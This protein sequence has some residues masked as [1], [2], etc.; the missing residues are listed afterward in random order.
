MTDLSKDVQE[1][2]KEALSRQTALNIYAGNSKAFIG[3]PVSGEPCCLAGHS[4]ILY[5]QPTEL[6]LT[7]RSGTPLSLIEQTLAEN[8]QMLAFEP[9]HFS[10]NA[11]LGGVVSSALSGP[12]SVYVGTV[13][14]FVLGVRLLNGA[15]EVV[16]FGGEVMKNVAGYD[17]SRLVVGALGTLGILL[18]ISLKVLPMPEREVT[19]TWR[20]DAEAAE[21]K[22]QQLARKPWPLSAS[23]YQGG[24]FS[25]RL[26][27]SHPGVTEAQAALG[28]TV[29]EDSLWQELRERR[30]T[31]WQAVA[32]V[33]PANVLALQR[34]VKDAMDS[35]GI[36]NPGRLFGDF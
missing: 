26:S 27:G 20:L 14:D 22:R 34:R 6:V 5:Y 29:T 19:L 13:R 24:C 25:I 32:P 16:R 15:G 23:H 36:F 30:P 9:P 7:A 8:R 31:Q 21:Q 12:R 2:V 18:D 35:A 4:G 1:Q 17:V 33:L 11:T 28:G 10:S 3:F